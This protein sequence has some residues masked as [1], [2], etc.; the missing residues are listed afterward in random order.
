[1]RKKTPCANKE[2]R[3][4]LGKQITLQK[5]EHIA[6]RQDEKR[7][8]AKSLYFR[9]GLDWETDFTHTNPRYLACIFSQ[10]KTLNWNVK[11]FIPTLYT[12]SVENIAHATYLLPI[13]RECSKY[14]TIKIVLPQ[15]IIPPCCIWRYWY[16]ITRIFFN[17]SE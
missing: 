6:V 4:M 12:Y 9:I 17:F 2:K 7:I 1:M 15:K 13:L 14:F 3:N 5:V 11:T 16:L 8:G 10:A